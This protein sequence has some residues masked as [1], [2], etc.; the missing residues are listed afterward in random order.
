MFD[1][2]G[3]VVGAFGG[4]GMAAGPVLRQVQI[5]AQR[6]GVGLRLAMGLIRDKVDGARPTLLKLPPSLARELAIHR[7]DAAIEELETWPPESIETLRLIEARAAL[8]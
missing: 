6:N 1:W 7:L 4:T 2:Q 8:A 3:D 5:E